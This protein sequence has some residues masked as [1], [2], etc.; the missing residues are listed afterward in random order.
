[1]SSSRRQFL[2]G[3]SLGAS[4]TV[5]GPILQRLQAEAAG[6]TTSTRRFVFVIEGNGC[7]AKQIQ[8]K[9][10]RRQADGGNNSTNVEM[11]DESLAEH[12][13]SFAM[14][15][16]KPFQDRV[17]ILQ[18]LSGRACGGGHSNNFGALGVYSGKKGP[19]GETIDAALARALPSVFPH[20]GL[21]IS[22]KPEHTVI[23]NTSASGPGRAMPIQCRPDLAYQMLFGS[24]AE[25][26]GRQTFN[27]QGN[28][29]D[30][31]RVD[32]RNVERKLASPE[33]EKFGQY[34]DSLEALRQRQS[35]LNEIESTLR[36]HRPVV[37]D[38][39]SSAV[40]TD[41]LDAHFDLAAAALSAGMTN[42][43][44]LASGCGDPYFE[45]RF[46]GLGID[47]DKH[48]IGHAQGDGKRD[49]IEL[50]NL[51]R[52]FHFELI[53]R[54][55]K[56]LQAVPEGDGTV[57]DNTMI[58]YLSDGAER[59]HS[60]CYEWP[61]VLIGNLGGQLKTNGRYLCWPKH[62]VKGHRTLA[63]LYCTLLHAAGAPRD[64]FGQA[65]LEL[66]DFD[67]TGPL[68]ELL[69]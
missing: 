34:L 8:P 18:G 54:L 64:T 41:R 11:Q 26:A 16:L 10:I 69:A 23:Y 43:V 31:L 1:M 67:Q 57:L 66:K 63:N 5:L 6:H 35:R 58:L 14:E 28:L 44:T 24:V 46:R 17:A 65:D 47:L 59:H 29:L 32:V 9:T 36:K 53:A 62:G 51:I 39:F 49:S 37:S 33:K 55:M 48:A 42:V 3:V 13:L 12:E 60:S 2:K 27:L 52:R 30:S 40:E 4:A 56:K 50:M 38:K 45:V 61:M 19:A 25:G 7:P 15:P 22:S 68:A 21:G 20:V